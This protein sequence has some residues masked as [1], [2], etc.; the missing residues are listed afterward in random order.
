VTRNWKTSDVNPRLMTAPMVVVTFTIQRDGTVTNVRVS[1]KSGI[2]PLD[3]SAQRA[4]LDSA[5]F[6]PLPAGFPR[7]QADVELRF[8]LKR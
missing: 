4:V 8:E 7:S 1:Q 3:I 5:P 6:Q 2:E